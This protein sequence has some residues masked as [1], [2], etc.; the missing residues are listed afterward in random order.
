MRSLAPLALLSALPIL[1]ATAAA[2][3]EQKPGAAAPKGAAIQHR[4]LGEDESRSQVLYVDQSDP[5]KDWTLKLPSKCRDTQLIGDGKIMLSSPDGYLEYSLADR[6]LLKQVKG[7]PGTTF[8]RRLPNGHTILGG[9]EKGVTVRELDAQDKVLRTANFPSETGV[10][11]GRLTPEG[12]VLFGSST[13]LVEGS[14]DGKTVRSFP[15]EGAKHLYM[16]LRKPDGHYLVAAGYG[17]CFLELDAEGKA[18][19][20]FGGKQAP[21]AQALGYHFYS[22]FQVLKN[23][24]VVQCN[25]TG[26]GPND[27][28][29][30]VQLVEFDTDGKVV[31]KWHD[32]ARAGTLH[33]VIVLDDLDTAVL[34]D[35]ATSVLGPVAPAPKG[36]KD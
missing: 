19:K 2:A 27:S 1:C 36:A 11:L 15:V 21:D 5:A 29:K 31:W 9:N 32:A 25:W 6:K 35:D 24:H 20:T 3:E 28:A 13:K 30:G 10:R 7:Y 23:G 33:G 12:T 34:N 16:A 26:H 17:A 8:A 14:L 4:F 18:L 22:G